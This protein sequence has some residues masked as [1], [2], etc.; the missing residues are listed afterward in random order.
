MKVAL[1]P[2]YSIHFP[3]VLYP[4]DS[5]ICPLFRL[6]AL[7]HSVIL[8]QVHGAWLPHWLAVQLINCQVNLNTLYDCEEKLLSRS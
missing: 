8:N 2:R 1:G 6:L 4:M 5:H 7:M 3:V